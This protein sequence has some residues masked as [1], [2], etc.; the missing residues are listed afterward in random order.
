MEESEDDEEPPIISGLRV[1]Q[2]GLQ[3]LN[4]AYAAG[5]SAAIIK[6]AFDRVNVQIAVFTTSQ[7][8]IT[9]PSD[10]PAALRSWANLYQLEKAIC[11]S[12]TRVAPESEVYHVQTYCDRNVLFARCVEY[13]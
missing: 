8:Q 3:M 7:N 6:E 11:S 5:N 1:L 13:H 2:A 9:Q 12:S 10:V 4:Q